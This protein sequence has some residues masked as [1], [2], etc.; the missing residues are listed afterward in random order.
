LTGGGYSGIMKEELKRV[1]V[2][3]L[4]DFLKKFYEKD[5]KCYI[6]GSTENL[7]LHHLYS[8]SN[9]WN[10]WKESC[11]LDELS[12]DDIDDLRATFYEENKDSLGNHNL[13]TLCKRHHSL[14]HHFYGLT[15]TN[16]KVPKIRRWIEIQKNKY[17]EK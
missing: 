1:E 4:R 14:L 8:L 6:C 9:L 17:Q 16:Y 15:Y 7:E 13:V 3:Y 11:E 12:I 10:E 5:D 2:K